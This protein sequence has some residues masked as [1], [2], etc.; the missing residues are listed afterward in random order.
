LNPCAK[1]VYQQQVLEV[2]AKISSLEN[3]QLIGEFDD[4]ALQ[5]LKEASNLKQLYLPTESKLASQTYL[6][7]L[8]SL[9]LLRCS[10][11]PTVEALRQI[12]QLPKL[13]ELIIPNSELQASDLSDLP[14][15][16]QLKSLDIYG[17]DCGGGGLRNLSRFPSLQRLRLGFPA[18]MRDADLKHLR[19]LADLREL[20]LLVNSVGDPGVKHI[21]QLT[22]LRRLGLHHTAVSDA[23][24]IELTTLANLEE[25][26]CVG[27]RITRDG[28]ARFQR[29]M[30]N[31]DRV[32][33]GF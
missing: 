15:M 7:N 17:I 25:L 14:A 28:A 21:K 23:G 1:L 8:K 2:V 13:S 22:K 16:P 24:L 30:P 29:R 12:A 9:E 5:S 31:L 4:S 18:D 11:R 10:E 20:T 6:P 19:Q 3:L 33:F 26:S 32:D 27:S